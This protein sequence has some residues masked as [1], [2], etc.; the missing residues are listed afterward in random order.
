MCNKV[1]QARLAGSTLLLKTEDDGRKMT[2]Q[3]TLNFVHILTPIVA[4]VVETLF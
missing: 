4:Y 3:K 1:R 2:A